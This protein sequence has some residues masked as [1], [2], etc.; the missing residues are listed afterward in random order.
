MPLH[1]VQ[2]RPRIDARVVVVV[3]VDRVVQMHHAVRGGTGV[4]DGSDDLAGGD[5]RAV[6]DAG[7]DR[8]EVT[9]EVVPTAGGP[10]RHLVAGVAAEAG[11]DQRTVDRGGD[12]RA[13]RGPG[14]V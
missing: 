7:R 9:K 6:D 3:R 4:A 10:D 13:A 2:I 14:V 8:I 11:V 5:L 12:R 1:R